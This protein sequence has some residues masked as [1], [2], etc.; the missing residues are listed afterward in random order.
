[1]AVAA[2]STQ[3]GLLSSRGTANLISGTS[4]PAHGSV[5]AH[6]I[7]NE[8]RLDICGPV[9]RVLGILVPG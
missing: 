1:M 7:S 9:S 4:R 2:A 3:A 5:T 6:Q 8:R